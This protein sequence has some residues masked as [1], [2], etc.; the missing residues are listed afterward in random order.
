MKKITKILIIV[1]II[2]SAITLTACSPFFVGLEN[3]R[4]SSSSIPPSANNS[5]V[6]APSAKY[7]VKVETV[8][9]ALPQGETFPDVVEG[10]Q[11]SVVSIKVKTSNGSSAGSGVIYATTKG[12][13]TSDENILILTCSHVIESAL[14]EENGEITAVL[15]DGTKVK[16]LVLGADNEEDLAV[17]TMAPNQTLSKEKY[18]IAKIRNIDSSN[19][20]VKLRVAETV[21]AIGNPL[22]TLGGSVTKGIIS[23]TERVINMDGV[24][25]TLLQID[26]A[27]NR[28]N[29]GGALFDESGLLIGIVNAK[30]IGEG[31]EGIGYAISIKEALEIASSIVETHGLLKFDNLGYIEGKVR[32]GV[33]VES[34]PMTNGELYYKIVAL[35]PYGTVAV[36]NKGNS[37]KIMINQ[38]ISGI[39]KKSDSTFTKFTTLE[40]LGN[41]IKSL[42][43]GDEIVMQIKT[44]NN[45]TFNANLKMQ[46]YVFGFKP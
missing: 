28:G 39:K 14:T 31:V 3:D 13:N 32:L 2:S 27:V 16:C 41:F 29:S 25:M 44:A 46:Q 30:S 38:Y 24:S 9:P 43:V 33:T 4:N 45:S 26:V 11:N 19:G 10:V 12:Q 23:G 35:N 36:Y 22:G 42:K 17:L 21:F 15:Y 40:T 8:N 6:V 5:S 1:L 37:S 20:G 34:T 7:E 18:S